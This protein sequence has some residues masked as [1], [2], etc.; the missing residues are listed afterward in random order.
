[1]KQSSDRRTATKS[2]VPINIVNKKIRNSF[3]RAWMTLRQN[4]HLFKHGIGVNFHFYFGF[5]WF[6]LIPWFTNRQSAETSMHFGE[7]SV[8]VT[9]QLGR[10]AD[11]ISDNDEKL[12]LSGPDRLLDHP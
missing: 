6:E 11:Q 10:G 12:H 7:F 9:L 2:V 8:K 5:I 3:F 4:G 1:M